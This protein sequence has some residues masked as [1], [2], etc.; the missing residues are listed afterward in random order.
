[1]HVVCSCLSTYSAQH[2]GGGELLKLDHMKV[3]LRLSE[4]TTQ[5]IWPLESNSDDSLYGHFSMPQNC[6]LGATDLSTLCLQDMK[7]SYMHIMAYGST[8]YVG[9]TPKKNGGHI[10]SAQMT[11]SKCL[12]RSVNG[13]HEPYQALSSASM[14]NR[15]VNLLESIAKV[16]DRQSLKRAKSSIF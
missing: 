2:L 13:F 9:M 1:M 5:D 7:Q 15:T 16:P 12:Q 11:R 10:K 14:G 3:L 8:P 6:L 4:I